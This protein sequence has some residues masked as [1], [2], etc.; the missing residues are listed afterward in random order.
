MVAQ[1][2]ASSGDAPAEPAQASRSGT[3]AGSTAC[4]ARTSTTARSSR[5]TT[6]PATCAP[7]SAAPATTATTSRAGGSSPSS[8]PPA[9]ASASRAR[10]SSR[11]LY[12]T[13]FERKGADAR[14]RCCWTSR[15]TSTARENWAPKD[16]DRLERGPGPR[17][18][19]A[20][21]VA[22]HAGHPRARAGRQ[23]GGRGRRRRRWASVP[24]R[25]A[26]VHAGRAR[27]RARDGGGPAR[28]TSSSAYG[29]IANGGVHDAGP[30]DPRDPGPDGK[31]VWKAPDA[32]KRAMSAAAAY[33]VTDILEGQHGPGGQR[34]LGGEARDP[35][36]AGR[37]AAA[38]CGQDRD[39]DRRPGPRRRTATSRRP[40]TRR[41]R[42]SRSASGWATATTR[43]RGRR[44]PPSPSPPPPRCGDRRTPADQRPAGRPTSGSPTASFARGSTR[45]SGGAPGAVDARDH[46]PSC[47]GPARSR[48]PSNAIDRPGLLYS[49]SCGTWVVDPVTAELGPRSLGCRRRPDWLA[50]ARRGVGVGGALGSRTAFFWGRSGW[51]GPLLGACFVPSPRSAHGNGNGH[52][53][54]PGH[55]PPGGPPGQP[56]ASPP[57][58]TQPRRRRPGARL[59]RARRDRR[60]SEP[61]GGRYGAIA[62]RS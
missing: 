3:G 25:Q 21:D 31:V 32:G 11:S 28:S 7:T 33:L 12:A 34:D 52:G 48:A 6:G 1:P 43:C 36:R 59:H 37:H 50:R 16:A 44:T 8:T 17:P 58:G 51:G 57:A 39:R 20:P 22:Q 62:M 60:R 55:G 42:R 13:A 24:G 27:R 45:W 47:S 4:G 61:G 10:R 18:P 54:P 49:P 40:P 9:S 35:Q 29:T 30:D 56:P 19:G 53:P 5:S 15:P 2:A 38:G 46:A 23:R 14:H 26:G 41:R